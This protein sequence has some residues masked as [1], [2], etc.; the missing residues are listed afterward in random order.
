M[1][2]VVLALLLLIATPFV[3]AQESGSRRLPDSWVP[4]SAMFELRDQHQV[5]A[6]GRFYRGSDGSTRLET[7]PSLD[8]VT[9]VQIMNTSLASEW[10]WSPERGWSAGWSSGFVTF[11]GLPGLEPLD[12]IS[13]DG[14]ELVVKKTE[15]EL[16]VVA[17]ELNDF[18]MVMAVCWSP[19]D[20]MMTRYSDIEL[21]EQPMELFDVSGASPFRR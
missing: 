19:D 1:S 12:E 2:S 13:E 3:A 16:W 7:G 14:L 10:V 20:C 15:T 9:T 5:A 8:E 4:F 11:T 21:G 6:V 18:P 17:P